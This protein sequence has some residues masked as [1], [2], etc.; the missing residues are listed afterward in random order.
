MVYRLRTREKKLS[1]IL[2][3]CMG[4]IV[5]SFALKGMMGWDGMGWVGLCNWMDV[6]GLV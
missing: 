5:Y 6:C 3:F 4:G 2:A 1:V